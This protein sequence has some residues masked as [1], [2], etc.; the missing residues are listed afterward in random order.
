MCNDLIIFD[1]RK[2]DIKYKNLFYNIVILN[3]YNSY[4]MIENV[5]K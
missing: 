2:Y 4:G 1:Y 5:R 3:L